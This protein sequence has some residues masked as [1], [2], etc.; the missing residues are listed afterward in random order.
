V[1]KFSTCVPAEA[2]LAIIATLS[3]LPLV[4]KSALFEAR[5]PLG[6]RAI[7]SHVLPEVVLV[8]RNLISPQGRVVLPFF[9]PFRPL[10][11]STLAFS[12]SACY[13]FSVCDPRIGHRSFSADT[14]PPFDRLFFF[15]LTLAPLSVTQGIPTPL[16]QRPGSP[17]NLRECFFPSKIPPP[18]S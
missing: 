16:P 14:P 11:P 4:A 6:S 9:S 10:L 7:S 3:S 8:G 5:F 13:A 1:N 12:A 18:P 15:L 17:I 2:P